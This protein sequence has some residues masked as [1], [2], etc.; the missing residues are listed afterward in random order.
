MA[1]ETPDE[2]THDCRIPTKKRFEDLIM[3]DLPQ[4]DR[5]AILH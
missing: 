2:T 5:K 4:D 1:D 3:D